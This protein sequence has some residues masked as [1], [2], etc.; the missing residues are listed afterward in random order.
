QIESGHWEIRFTPH[1]ALYARAN[2]PL[3]L[4]RELAALGEMHVR[5]ILGEVPPLPDFEPFAVYCS[6]EITLVSSTLT[7]APIRE[8]FEFVDGDCDISIV[9]VGSQGA[10]SAAIIAPPAFVDSELARLRSQEQ[11]LMALADD[12]MGELLS[13][14]PEPA[15]AAPTVQDSFEAAPALSFAEL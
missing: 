12:E 5:A 4:F 8:V 7:E 10:A 13:F 11:N 1:R 2:D 15:P 6:W 3:L 14:T 9:Q